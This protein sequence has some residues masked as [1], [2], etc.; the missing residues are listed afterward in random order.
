MGK[1]HEQIIYKKIK[2]WS[3]AI[4]KDV[5]FHSQYDKCKLKLD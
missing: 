5:Q 1:R 2:T 3:L 4:L